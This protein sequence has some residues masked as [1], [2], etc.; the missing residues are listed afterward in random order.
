MKQGF[1]HGWHQFSIDSDADEAYEAHDLLWWY[2]MIYI[3]KYYELLWHILIHWNPLKSLSCFRKSQSESNLGFRWVRSTTVNC[4]D[5]EPGRRSRRGFRSLPRRLATVRTGEPYPGAQWFPGGVEHPDWFVDQKY[6]LYEF[7]IIIY[8]ENSVLILNPI[9][10]LFH[11]FSLWVSISSPLNKSTINVK[12]LGAWPT[13]SGFSGPLS[14]DKTQLPKGGR[15]TRA[16]E[17]LDHVA[18][19]S[20]CLRSCL[21]RNPGHRAGFGLGSM[22]T[23][24]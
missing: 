13:A 15:A 4:P 14:G 9:I 1:Y 21:Q 23:Y 19:L 7:P 16:L 6:I 12:W 24:P 11:L 3:Y 2:I 20:S 5:A 18:R 17:N 8:R 10:Y 22:Y